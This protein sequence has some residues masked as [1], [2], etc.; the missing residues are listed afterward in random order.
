MRSILSDIGGAGAGKVPIDRQ[1]LKSGVIGYASLSRAPSTNGQHANQ[2]WLQNHTNTRA[3]I[4]FKM[5]KRS[6]FTN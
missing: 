3:Y 4:A 1:D 6:D 2:S 5:K